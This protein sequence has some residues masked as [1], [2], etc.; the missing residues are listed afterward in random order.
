MLPEEQK[1]EDCA[2]CSFDPMFPE[3]DDFCN[4]GDISN[5]K[6]C[7]RFHHY[8]WLKEDMEWDNA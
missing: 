2:H 7:G 5:C 4:I 3:K 1:K 8:Q 6:E